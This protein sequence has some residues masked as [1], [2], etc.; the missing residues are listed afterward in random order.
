MT[1]TVGPFG[2]LLLAGHEWDK[3]AMWRRSLELMAAEVAP[4]LGQHMRSRLAAE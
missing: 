1:E 3:A 4:R 2:T